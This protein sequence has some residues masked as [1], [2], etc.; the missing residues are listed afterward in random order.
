M[1]RKAERGRLD[2]EDD[3]EVDDRSESGEESPTGES[4]ET[5]GD[6]PA[7][8]QEYM[9]EDKFT[10]VT[11]EPMTNDDDDGFSSNQVES[12]A[13][14]Q[15]DA[16]DGLKPQKRLWTKKR[17]DTKKTKKK[18]FRYETKSERKATKLYQRAKNAKAAQTRRNNE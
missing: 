4:R 12:T 5:E 1:V 8:E 18:K 13:Q 17:P 2:S 7:S 11:I 3:A 9:D 16:I 15:N 10:T 6:V 14:S